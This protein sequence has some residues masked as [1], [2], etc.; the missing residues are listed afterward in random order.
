MPAPASLTDLGN[1]QSLSLQLSLLYV[2]P[3]SGCQHRKGDNSS[4]FWNLGF[5]MEKKCIHVRE[6][7]GM[8]LSLLVLCYT[9]EQA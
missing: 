2:P 7:F 8:D 5:D 9:A 3:A 6:N 4:P 1:Q